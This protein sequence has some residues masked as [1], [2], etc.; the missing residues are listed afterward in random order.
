[1]TNN[2]LPNEDAHWFIE[3]EQRIKDFAELRVVDKHMEQF[4]YAFEDIIIDQFPE[5][6]S[7]G[8]EDEEAD[9]RRMDMVYEIMRRVITKRWTDN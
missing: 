5:F 2:N 9:E 6:A 3:N 8:V 4:A 7:Q 1:M